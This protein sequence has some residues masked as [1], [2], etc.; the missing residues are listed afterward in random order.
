M[1]APGKR[2]NALQ[3]SLPEMKDAF[4]KDHYSLSL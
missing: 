3:Q 1:F 4:L 2:R